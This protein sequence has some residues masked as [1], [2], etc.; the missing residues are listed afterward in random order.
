MGTTA[1]SVDTFY[2][3][4]AFYPYIPAPVFDALEAAYLEGKE[5]AL[6]ADSDYSEMLNELK[7]AGLCPELS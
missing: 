6:V 7:A 3:N 2:S 1:I 5:T 4:R